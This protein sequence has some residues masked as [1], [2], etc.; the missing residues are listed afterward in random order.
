MRTCVR[1]KEAMGGARG[2]LCCRCRGLNQ[3]IAV[4]TWPEVRDEW[5]R[6]SGEDISRQ[7]VQ[8][9]GQIAQRKIRD[10]LLEDPEIRER[11]EEMGIETEP[12]E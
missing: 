2:R 4:R 9:I 8:D 6:M 12:Y 1:C 3:Q 5:H 11:V 10:A 7:R